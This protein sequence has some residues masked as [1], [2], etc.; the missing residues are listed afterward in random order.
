MR[1]FKI[2]FFLLSLCH[3]AHSQD[4]KLKKANKLF[5]EKS[6]VKA[7]EIY[8]ELKVNDSSL[9]NLADAYY[10]NSM[11]NKAVEN[12]SKAIASKVTIPND[13]YFKYAQA[14]YGT[15]NISKADSIMSNYKDKNINSPS[16]VSK[17]N[18]ANPFIYEIKQI[19]KGA[20]PGDFGINYFGDKLVFSSLRNTDS[21]NYNWN[22][23]PYLDLYS[24][25]FTEN[26]A[27]ENILPFNSDVN[28]KTHESNAILTNDGKTMYF[29]RTSLK[30]FKIGNEKIATVRLYK[31]SLIDNEW[32]K[33]EEL[34]FSSELYSI[35]HPCLN[36]D[37]SKLYFSSD[38]PGGK[39]SFDI[40]YVTINGEEYG[41]PINL[42][43]SINTPQ[44]EQ[45]PF[46]SKTGSLYFASNGLQ[47]LGGLDVFMCEFNNETW[48]S[49]LN[50]GNTLNS[51][52]DDFGFIVNVEDNTGFFSSNREGDDHLYHFNRIEN[53]RKL[54]VKG[55]VRDKNSKELLSETLVTL[56]DENNKPIDSFKV[57][58]DG[59]YS[60][61]VKPYS[62]FKIEGYKPFYIPN[63]INFETDDSGIIELNIELEI[64]TYDDAEEL[65]V[66]KE[67]GY[68]YIELENI[69]FDL[70]KWDIKPNA[71]KTLDIL[72]NLM[73]K[74][75]RMEVQ[76]GAHTDNRSTFEYNLV[77]SANRAKS[78]MNYIL[79]KGIEANRLTSKGYGESKLLVNCGENCTEEEHAINRRCEFIIMK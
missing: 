52:L 32:T 70:D 25:N 65:I 11:M 41:T 61:K 42:G 49:P 24:A 5:M 64:E 66:E 17:V 54:I 39:G 67:D 37:N 28:S 19:T 20:Q 38:M 50:L 6:Y 15:N 59:K 26:S 60:F 34:P 40:Y 71:G 12:Y 53:E 36:T 75:P 78:A 77:L 69:Y 2:F 29:S 31:A 13:M 8:E 57:G 30:R 23:K 76:L 4:A 47:G 74:Y 22:E 58:L 35:Q 72:V 7:A 63:A 51:P 3:V 1:I 9:I 45:F 62:S 46:I 68:V 14:L 18:M 21:K 16:F 56:F 55:L 79:S 43:E 10:Y 48:S 27:L 33:I 73:K 44:L